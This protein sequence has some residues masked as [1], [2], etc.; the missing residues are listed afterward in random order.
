MVHRD[1]L[2]FQT[3]HQSSELWLKL[4]GFELEGAAAHLERREL[5]AALRLLTRAIGCIE[6]ITNQIHMLERC[7]RGSPGDST[8][9]E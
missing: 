7:R 6:L 3:T 2:I 9:D 5:D 8:P 1:E 4:A